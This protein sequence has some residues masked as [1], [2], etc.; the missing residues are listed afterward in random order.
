MEQLISLQ[1]EWAEDINQQF[2]RCISQI[3]FLFFILNAFWSILHLPTIWFILFLRPSA[4]SFPFAAATAAKR[5][6]NGVFP[7]LLSPLPLLYF[8]P[9]FSPVEFIGRLHS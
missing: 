4:D 9:F 1:T 7:D 6:A 5:H 2:R 3:A 8:A